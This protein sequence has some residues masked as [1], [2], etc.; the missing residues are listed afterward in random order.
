MEKSL[1]FILKYLL[2]FLFFFIP[3]R[4][5]IAYYT[6]DYI[7]FIPDAL[8]WSL[9]LFVI[10]KNKFKLNLKSYDY[11]YIGFIIVG[12]I[13]T[14]INDISV[15][16]FAMQVRSIGTLYV[17]F[18]ILRN[19]NMEYKD[20]IPAVKTLNLV[21]ITFVLLSLIEIISNK[22]ILFPL[23]WAK[24]ISF[25]SNY[26]RAYSLLFNP[27]VYGAFLLF[28]II[29]NYYCEMTS[30]KKIKLNYLIYLLGYLG[31]FLSSS[32]STFLGC[33][34]FI[35]FLIYNSIREKKFKSL[36]IHILL[37]I[38]A[39][40][41]SCG[42]FVLRNKLEIK[43]PEGTI[44]NKI[45][46]I[47]NDPDVPVVDP[48]KPTKP[49]K[50]SKPNKNGNNNLIGRF[51]EVINGTTKEDSEQNGRIFIIKK[52]LEIFKNNYVIGTGFGTFGSAGSK[53]VTPT[54]LY[55][56]YGLYEG[57]YSDNE[58]IKVV[59]ETGALGVLTF[60]SFIL[61]LFISI[62]KSR[63]A[64]ILFL[65]YWYLGM[66]YNITETQVVTLLFYIGLV[67]L[68]MNNKKEVKERKEDAI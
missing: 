61:L 21:T 24:G 25:A 1:R 8:I 35:L 37:G 52:G 46:D 28:V 6:V 31:I 50:P 9:L 22:S 27:N 65:I 51:E 53:M 19:I 49:S 45:P 60:G 5:V 4:E 15:M 39:F 16:A 13:S 59:V 47:D 29:I 14:L 42:V 3:F 38:V 34:L 43:A 18:Y 40:G 63:Y 10:I 44:I 67:F 64:V 36:F 68:S 7:K 26:Y 48:T 11:F 54:K 20:Y 30:N 23:E 66:F 33:I 58:Y 56:K 62:L 17:L 2:V 12:F 41:L 32:R 55:E 57:F